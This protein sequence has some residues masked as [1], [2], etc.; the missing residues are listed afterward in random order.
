MPATTQQA[1]DAIEAALTNI[2][3][4]RVF[5]H[6][7]DVFATPCAFCLPDT[8]EY[9]DSFSSGGVIQEFTVTLVV[10]RTSDRAAQRSLYDYTSYSGSSSI[11]AT[12][13]ADPTLGGVVQT[14]TVNTASNIRM[15]SQGDATFLA[16]DFDLTVY[17]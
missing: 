12:I 9:H 2:T 1:A 8:I 13:E 11:R 7:P 17:A 6:V 5:D 10:G 15:L 3:G 14:S 16:V 4:L